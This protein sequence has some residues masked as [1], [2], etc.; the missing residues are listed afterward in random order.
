MFVVFN[1]TVIA[2][3]PS[4]VVGRDQRLCC[5]SSRTRCTCR[6]VTDPNNTSAFSRQP[7]SDVNYP[8]SDSDS[9]IPRTHFTAT[10]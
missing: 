7:N 5:V 4:E 2:F 6:Q 10:A 1:T 3:A 8:S 9:T